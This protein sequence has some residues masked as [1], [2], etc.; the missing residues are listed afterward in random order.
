MPNDGQM[1]LWNE[2]T[3]AWD[4]APQEPLGNVD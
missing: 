3:G 4:A 2:E 1:Y